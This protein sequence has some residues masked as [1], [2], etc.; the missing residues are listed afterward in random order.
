MGKAWAVKSTRLETLSGEECRRLLAS[1]SVGRL[2]VVRGGFPLIIPVNYALVRDRIVVH[3]DAGTKFSAA[4][5]NR[6]SFE[7]D[8]IDAGTR[9]GWSVLVQG[10]AVEVA[11]AEDPFYEE[12]TNTALE[13]WAP[14]ERSRV[15]LVTPIAV[16]GRRILRPGPRARSS[17]AAEEA[18]EDRPS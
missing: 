1:E 3:T 14:G 4:R 5:H 8:R 15:L 6:V 11:S 10:F 18:S 7:V 17:R 16:T 12:V 9:S 13:P 2:G